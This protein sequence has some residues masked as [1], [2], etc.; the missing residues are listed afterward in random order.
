[1]TPEQRRDWRDYVLGAKTLTLA[2]RIV[3]LA[4]ETFADYADGTN[5]RPGIEGLM[6]KCGLTERAVETALKRGRELGLIQRT[7]NGFKRHA[8]EYRL[9]PIANNPHGGAGQNGDTPHG[10]AGQN[11]QSPHSGAGQRSDSPHGG[12]SLTRTVVPPTT[13]G[14]HQ[15]RGLRHGGTELDDPGAY[16]I[17][18]AS[19]LRQS[20]NGNAAGTRCVKHAHIA[21]DAWVG[22]NCRDC[23]ALR[24]AAKA[25]QADR[26]SAA[27]QTIKDCPH[28]DDLGRI[29]IVSAD[30]EQLAPCPRHVS[31]AQAQEG[32]TA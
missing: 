16:A 11:S 15:K 27:I 28:C 4:L 18:P 25:S 2:Q 5:A 8:A 13:S 17:N 7:A 3:L 32:R 29:E 30:V 20:A 24:K 22:E 14:P 10:R 21:P 9:V 26:K 31:W 12:A 6:R 23:A 19:G 1:M